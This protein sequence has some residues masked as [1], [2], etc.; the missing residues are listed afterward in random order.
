MPR[1]LGPAEE[2]PNGYPEA[3]ATAQKEARREVLKRFGRYAAAAP[4]A[5]LL[6]APREGEAGR[7]PWV[8][9]PPPSHQPPNA[10]GYD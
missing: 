2:A 8:P 9:D 4:T 10:G 1:S 3:E 6:L 7:P 5:M